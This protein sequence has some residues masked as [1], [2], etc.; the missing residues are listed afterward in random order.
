VFSATFSISGLSVED[1]I[2]VPRGHHNYKVNWKALSYK[3]C[4]KYTFR[5]PGG[6]VS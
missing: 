6:S 1:L 4:I 3:N 2:R 5:G